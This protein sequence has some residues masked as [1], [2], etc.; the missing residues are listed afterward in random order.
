ML[1]LDDLSLDKIIVDEQEDF[2]LEIDSGY[3]ESPF[4]FGKVEM[5]GEGLDKMNEKYQS[6]QRGN[7]KLLSFS[8]V[9]QYFDLS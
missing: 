6:S 5:S 4:K 9:V 2:Y 7:P 8:Q 1:L 3:E